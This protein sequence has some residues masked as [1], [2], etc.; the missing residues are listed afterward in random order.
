MTKKEKYILVLL[1]MVTLASYVLAAVLLDRFEIRA[2][3]IWLIPVCTLLVWSII[4]FRKNKCWA[5]S[6]L[7]IAIVVLILAIKLPDYHEY[8]KRHPKPA[9]SA[10][11]ELK[12]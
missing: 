11:Q 12:R 4:L 1:E 8:K 2:G 9:L 3:I 7:I 5:L 10:V 6:G